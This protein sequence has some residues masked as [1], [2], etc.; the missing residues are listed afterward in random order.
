MQ[1]VWC[2]CVGPGNVQRILDGSAQALSS[3]ILKRTPN[4]TLGA[5]WLRAFFAR[6]RTSAALRVAIGAML[7]DEEMKVTCA[8]TICAQNAE[9]A[10][11]CLAAAS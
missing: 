2:Y 5:K 10:M 4:R 9:C 1:K 6:N 8:G 11:C 3:L 7:E